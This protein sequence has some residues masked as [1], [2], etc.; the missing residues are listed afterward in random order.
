M[1][2]LL[3]QFLLE[4]LWLIGQM[5]PYLTLGFAIAGL[6]H[7]S[8]PRTIVAEYLGRESAG[9]AWRAAL[10]GVPLPLCSCGVVPTAIGLR[11]RG[12]SRAATVSFLISTPQTGV[13]SILATFGF[14]GWAF[15]IFRPVAAFVSG[16][17]G[18]VATLFLKK[19]AA[20][21]EHWL[22]Y[23]VAAEDE[24]AQATA[25]L[26][27]PKKLRNGMRFA[28]IELL[29]D[30]A[31]WLVL[32]L[33]AAALIS[34]AIPD[35][36][37]ASRIP[38][39]IAQMLVM[40]AFGIPLYVCSTA[41]IPIAAVLMA[42]GISAGAAFVFLMT[43]PATNAATMLIIARVMGWRVLATY[44]GSI[45]LLALGFGLGL[46]WL[47][48]HIGLSVATPMVHHHM[49]PDWITWGSAGLLTFFIARHFM[50]RID[51]RFFRRKT[52]SEQAVELLI[53]GMTCSHCVKTVSDALKQVP[54]VT[55]ADVNLATGRAQVEGKNLDRD[56]LKKAVE[57]VGYR[58]KS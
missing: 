23:H 35:D 22:K 17:V 12:A 16:L 2:D 58:I 30:I 44:L 7:A 28:F 27:L 3:R 1:M 8:V 54:G 56:A 11:K 19:N 48:A 36:F 45:A 26:P 52:V 13:D 39:G 14:F 38:P 21:D 15:A 49:L 29:G 6:L 51:K 50:D 24:L 40:M 41:S 57:S 18:G 53:E 10:I 46:D 37:L 34:M 32:G 9:S 47:T 4:N 55:K 33:A 20:Q 43:G 25:A 31:L 42:K 5:A